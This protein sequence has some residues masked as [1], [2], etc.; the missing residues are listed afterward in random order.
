QGPTYIAALPGQGDRAIVLNVVSNDA[1]YLSQGTDGALEVRTYQI[2][3]RANAWA[4]S[5]DGRWAIAWTDVTRVTKPDVIEGFQQISITDLQ[6]TAAPSRVPVRTV[7]F[8]PN[9]ISFAADPPRAFAVTEDGITVVDLSTPRDP[10]VLRT[11]QLEA[12]GTTAAAP[13]EL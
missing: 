8:R 11:L 1:T 7:G 6:D 5:P 2:A 10:R 9:S 13:S 3:P 4:I 12:A